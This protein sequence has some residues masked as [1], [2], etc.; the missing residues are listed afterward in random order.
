MLVSKSADYHDRYYLSTE[1]KSAALSDDR[2]VYPGDPVSA[3]NIQNSIGDVTPTVGH[4]RKHR[5]R[6]PKRPDL[7]YSWACIL[8][9]S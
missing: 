1:K 3:N 9:R 7:R 8:R 2:Y 6:L 5:P 4:A